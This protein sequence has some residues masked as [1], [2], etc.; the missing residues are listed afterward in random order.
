MKG[1]P[2][3]VLSAPWHYVWL[4]LLGHLLWGSY[5]VFAKRAVLEIPKFSLLVVASAGTMLVGAAV[6]R[7]YDRLSRQQVWA[8]LSREPALWALAVF[9]VTRSVT[10]IVSIELTRATWI[11]LV[12][13][14]TPF[15]VAFLGAW[16]FGQPVP[17]YTYR[18]LFLSTAGA[19]LMLVQDWSQVAAGFTTRDLLGLAVAGL[20][21]LALAT[22]FQLIRRSR[23]REATGGLIMFQQGLALVVTY[24]VL[25]RGA[26]EDWSAWSSASAMG[27]VAVAWVV[28]MVMMLGNLVQ[29]VAIGGTNPTLV[30][31]LM[32]LRLVSALI[33]G[34]WVLG[35][36]LV[37][38]SQWLGMVLVIVTVTAYLW[39][40]NRGST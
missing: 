37:I 16:F 14:L 10:N 7:W 33:L 22:Y 30:T 2:T 13:I 38:A 3:P 8:V 1:Q 31:S 29:I 4:G 9:A 11:Q 15:P 12:N 20:S 26:G 6:V 23:L 25:S 17:R 21:T 40:Q 39:L 32:A 18:A 5:P 34:W 24:V 19:A 28:G 36:R 35:E 27:W